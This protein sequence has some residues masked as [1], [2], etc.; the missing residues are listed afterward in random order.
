MTAVNEELAKALKAQADA[1]KHVEDVK[2]KTRDADLKIVRELCKAHG[3]TATNLKGYLKAKGKEDAVKRTRK[4]KE[5]KT[6]TI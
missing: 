4:P 3:F 5:Q 2:K 6:A 1:N